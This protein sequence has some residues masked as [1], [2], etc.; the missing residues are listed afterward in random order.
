MEEQQ[1]LPDVGSR[2]GVLL[3]P[4]GCEGSDIMSGFLE[5]LMAVVASRGD[6]GYAE[7]VAQDAL[8]VAAEMKDA[9]L[10][11][12]LAQLQLKLRQQLVAERMLEKLLA[13][14]QKLGDLVNVLTGAAAKAL[15]T[16]K[17]TEK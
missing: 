2:C 15:L 12:R 13:V 17:T 16:D 3:P 7:Q 9:E 8:L 14:P 6:L 11:F 1:R 10:T 4:N 5:R